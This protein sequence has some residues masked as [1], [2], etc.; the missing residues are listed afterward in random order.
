M[1]SWKVVNRKGST[2]RTNIRNKLETD[3]NTNPSNYWTPLTGQVE[4]LSNITQKIEI[5]Q[6]EKVKRVRLNT[7][8]KIMIEITAKYGVNE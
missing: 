1:G 8:Y 4:A 2:K 7:H 5:I 6:R 3:S